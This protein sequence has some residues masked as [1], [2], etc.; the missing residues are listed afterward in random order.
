MNNRKGSLWNPI[1]IY[2]ENE[3]KD[4]NNISTMKVCQKNMPMK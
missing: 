1:E 3:N 2:L 4:K